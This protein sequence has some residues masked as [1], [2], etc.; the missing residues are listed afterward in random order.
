MIRVPTPEEEA[1]RDLVRAREDVRQD[2][3]AAKHRLSKFLLRH[4]RIYSAG[5]PWTDRHWRWLNGQS[6]THPAAEATFR[7]YVDQVQQLDQTRRDLERQIAELAE[8]PPYR[9][10]VRRIS[11]LRGISVLGGTSL[12]AEIQDFRR[13]ARPRQLMGF[14]GVVPSER[15]SGG[16]EHRGG[17]TKTG[18]SHARRLLIE[19]AWTYRHPPKLTARQQRLL[20]DQPPETT[21][22]VKRAM[23]RLHRRYV[24]L[25]SRG[26][27]PQVA[28]TA[29]ARELCGF[30]WALMVQPAA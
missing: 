22:L 27:K 23:N 16:R 6:F 4:G 9:E 20:A 18:N 19:A 10:P 30:L 24:R 26:K 11:C 1:V 8:T 3:I 17:I 13:F 29:V 28:I 14:L 2:L 15:S 25:V 21:A 12:I 5:C 7:H